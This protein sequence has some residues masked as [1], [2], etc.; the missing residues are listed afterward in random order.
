MKKMDSTPKEEKRHFFLRQVNELESFLV[1][2][3]KLRGEV[4]DCFHFLFT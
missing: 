1:G 2:R 4:P 3:R